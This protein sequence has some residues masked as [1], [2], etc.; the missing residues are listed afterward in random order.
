MK[1]KG[2]IVLIVILVMIAAGAF[3]SYGYLYKDVRNISSEDASFKV[4]ASKL[5]SEYAGNQQK[6]D[7]AYLNKTVEIT[8]KV[9]QV[10]DSVLTVDSQV[11]CGFDVKPDAGSINKNVTIKGR[12]IGF[13]ELFGEVKL[14]QC[15]ITTK[16]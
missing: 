6:A 3:F 13:D 11:F 2:F 9:T 12:V 15:T 5:I 7:A 8:G 1:K 16:E 10:T 14:D 4:P